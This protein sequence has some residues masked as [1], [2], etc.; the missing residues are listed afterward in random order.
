M[1]SSSQSLHPAP[2][3]I[4]PFLSSSPAFSPTIPVIQ[5][6][7][8]TTIPLMQLLYPTGPFVQLLLPSNY[9]NILAIPSSDHSLH[10]APSAIQTCPSSSTSCHPTIPFIQP[11]LS[12]CHAI[13]RFILPPWLFTTPPP[14]ACTMHLVL[15]LLQPVPCVWSLLTSSL[16]HASR[17]CSP[18]A[19]HHA[20]GPCSP[21]A[22]TIRLVLALF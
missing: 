20:S 17:P 11:I 9:S 4:Q 13:I 3:V 8:N 16:Y 19:L 2:T 14:L 6:R 22:C 5:P 12:C 10:L 15:A 1:P 18:P 21:P 7:C